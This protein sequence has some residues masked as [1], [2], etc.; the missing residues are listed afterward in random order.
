MVFASHKLAKP[1]GINAAPRLRACAEGRM[2]Q[3]GCIAAQGNLCAGTNL[4]RRARLRGR[5]QNGQKF[6]AESMHLPHVLRIQKNHLA[7]AAQKLTRAYD[8]C[9]KLCQLAGFVLIAGKVGKAEA[10]APLYQLG[11]HRRHLP[12]GC[13]S[14]VAAP[15]HNAIAVRR[16]LT[17]GGNVAGRRIEHIDKICQLRRKAN[18]R[19][20]K[21]QREAAVGLRKFQNIDVACH[22][23]LSQAQHRQAV[24]IAGRNVHQNAQRVQPHRAAP[25]FQRRGQ[26]ARCKGLRA[27][28]GAQAVFHA[29]P[30]Q[31]AHCLRQLLRRN[32]QRQR[33]PGKTACLYLAR[34]RVQRSH[35]S[36]CGQAFL[37]AGRVYLASH[38]LQYLCLTAV[39]IQLSPCQNHIA[40]PFKSS[41]APAA[42]VLISFMPTRPNIS[43]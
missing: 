33:A 1:A 40:A 37:C 41:A 22:K 20:H 11:A 35:H 2:L 5:L 28:L 32:A 38:A 43:K 25:L 21:L 9:G 26:G 31:H 30:A 14:R 13:H 4:L 42:H 34:Q 39:F 18:Q 17:H 12:H 23:A 10:V 15:H 27:K 6:L 8:M 36:F 29:F 7:R 16:H 19:L 3:H 24:R